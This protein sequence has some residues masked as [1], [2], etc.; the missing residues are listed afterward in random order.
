MEENLRESS[1]PS[2]P[3]FF[4]QVQAALKRHRPLG[5][6]AR[7]TPPT[8]TLL[9]PFPLLTLSL[10]SVN[11]S[12]ASTQSHTLRPKR[13]MVAHRNVADKSE[14]EH[15]SISDTCTGEGCKN[16]PSLPVE[17]QSVGVHKKVR[18]STESNNATS[19]SYGNFLLPSA[20]FAYHYI[21]Q[22]FITI[23]RPEVALF[24]LWLLTIYP[25]TLLV[26]IDLSY[27]ALCMIK[28][29]ILAISQVPK[30]I[31][32]S[33]IS[34]FL[35]LHLTEKKY[36]DCCSLSHYIEIAEALSQWVTYR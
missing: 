28:T 5:I 33:L 3:E 12:S 35:Y 34:F 32:S 31:W 20:C 11:A 24:L 30:L 6:N 29:T 16:E 25:L 4:K 10:S 17:S 23:L 8:A 2:S 21:L 9:S 13:S 14:E 18:F 36:E 15:P 27:V 19:Q 1:S 7:F 26:K 22:I